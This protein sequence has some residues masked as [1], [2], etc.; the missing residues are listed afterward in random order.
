VNHQLPHAVTTHS[1]EPSHA[2]FRHDVKAG[3]DEGKNARRQRSASPRGVRQLQRE[4]DI[5]VLM[6][7]KQRFDSAMRRKERSEAKCQESGE[8]ERGS[9]GSWAETMRAPE[10]ERM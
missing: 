7:E 9:D 8:L 2:G 10:N 3:N 5:L 1:R 4:C 6:L